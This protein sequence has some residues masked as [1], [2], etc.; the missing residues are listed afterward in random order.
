M[1]DDNKIDNMELRSEKVR[2]IIGEVPPSL[3]RCGILVIAI[4]TVGLLAAS[5]FIHYPEMVT[6][7]AMAVD[8]RSALVYVPYQYVNEVEADEE[9][10]MEF[11]GFP[12]ETYNYKI[13]RVDAMSKTPVV[14]QAGNVFLVHVVLPDSGYGI[15]KNMSGTAFILLENKTILQHIFKL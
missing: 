3:V 14:Q 5:C 15:L 9:V 2:R 4:V 8:G 13:G 11:E 12:A 1:N 7:K 10:M 6:C